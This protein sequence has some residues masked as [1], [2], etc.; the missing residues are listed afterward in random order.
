[1]IQFDPFRLAPPSY[2]VPFLINFYQIPLRLALLGRTAYIY[3]GGHFRLAWRSN[4]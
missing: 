3:T 2:A 1:M 4:S